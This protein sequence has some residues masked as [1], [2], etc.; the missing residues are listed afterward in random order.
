MRHQIQKFSDRF[1]SYLYDSW[2]LLVE[3][4]A[5]YLVRLSYVKVHVS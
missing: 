3:K 5:V 4:Y 2:L 1:S